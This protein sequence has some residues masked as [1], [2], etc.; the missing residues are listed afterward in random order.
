M[1]RPSKIYY[2]L[3]Q[4]GSGD[5]QLEADVIRHH[6]I[7]TV[8]QP[9]WAEVIIE[10]HD[11]SKQTVYNGDGTYGRYTNFRRI[12]IVEGDTGK[13]SFLGRVEFCDSDNDPDGNGP[14]LKIQAKDHLLEFAYASPVDMDF[15]GYST[16][17]IFAT[18]AQYY[19]YAELHLSSYS[20][21]FTPGNYILA[22]YTGFSGNGMAKITFW[23]EDS[24]TLGITD[25]VDMYSYDPFNMAFMAGNTVTE[26]L[27]DPDTK[28][29]NADPDTGC[30]T[31][32]GVISLTNGYFYTINL[33]DVHGAS[34]AYYGN[35]RNNS[36]SALRILQQIA[37]QVD[38]ADFY[39][40]NSDS[41]ELIY[42][43][44]LGWYIGSEFVPV[45][46]HYIPRNEKVSY[47]KPLILGYDVTETDY[48]TVI[49]Y[50]ADYSFPT[51]EKERN[52][53]IQVE[54]VTDSS[55]KIMG[56]SFNTDIPK[57]YKIN[58]RL[59]TQNNDTVATEQLNEQAS[60]IGSKVNYSTQR[61][62]IRINK[63]PAYYDTDEEWH[64]LRAGDVV[65][66]Y[67]SR[68]ETVDD[69]P[70]MVI[71]IDY[72]ES[73][74]IA[75][76]ELVGMYYNFDL[77]E[78]TTAGLASNQNEYGSPDNTGVKD[79]TQPIDARIISTIGSTG[80][81]S[82]IPL[83]TIE[84]KGDL[85]IGTGAGAV[86][87]LD[88]GTV[89]DRVLINDGS[90]NISWG[91]ASGTG[92]TKLEQDSNPT[93]GGI[94]NCD[95]YQ[96]G[97][98]TVVINA[99]YSSS[100]IP[101]HD[102]S[103][104]I[105]G[106]SGIKLMSGYS[107]DD[108]AGDIKLTTYGSIIQEC[109][110]GIVLKAGGVASVPIENELTLQSV[111]NIKINPDGFVYLYN[112]L[113]QTNLD[114]NS[115]YRIT[116]LAHPIYEHD[117]IIQTE[118]I[119]ESA[120]EY[121]I[122]NYVG[123][124]HSLYDDDSPMLSTTLDTNGQAI[125]TTEQYM[126]IMVD[127]E[128]GNLYLHAPVIDIYNDDGRIQINSYDGKCYLD[129]DT[130]QIGN[131]S[132]VINAGCAVETPISNKIRIR[133]ASDIDIYAFNHIYESTASSYGI[134]IKAGGSATTPASGVLLLSATDSI[135]LLSDKAI[136]A[137]SA[138]GY[139]IS[140]Y[141]GSTPLSIPSN[142]ITFEAVNDITLHPT[143]DV[144]ITPHGNVDIIPGG[145]ITLHPASYTFIYHGALSTDFATNGNQIYSSA[146][147]DLTISSGGLGTTP[148]TSGIL[149]L[150]S[151]NY[152]G[153]S[154]A[155]NFG[156]SINAGALTGYNF[157]NNILSLYGKNGIYLFTSDPSYSIQIF[158]NLNLYDSDNDVNRDI[159]NGGT[160]NGNNGIFSTRLKIPVGSNMY[161]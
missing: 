77:G 97:N 120:L 19:R 70:M 98:N 46:M 138:S 139:G 113:L 96:I 140:L 153:I 151:N 7:D 104:S 93:L 18:I 119:T 75:T 11:H 23:D 5:W 66:V 10:D 52:S 91:S 135:S 78:W 21:S 160:I 80:G 69:K 108:I 124:L 4:V 137:T 43:E 133:A 117:A 82:G 116:N 131:N 8:N 111:G 1:S 28:I 73:P 9:R 134:S 146:S 3:A 92:M 83:S 53:I 142:D 81:G 2:E 36:Q 37:T 79:I 56:Q 129:T 35:F 41:E 15:R 27:C 51:P 47:M 141:A 136:Y 158:N 50:N 100:I 30:T 61:G 17:S 122:N 85:V 145:A 67:N 102:D 63:Y 68:L 86:T 125:A 127:N 147:Q 103:V 148:G 130:C 101:T 90:G 29:I 6:I 87:R 33:S 38:R 45:N 72:E 48:P 112:T 110:Y 89:A 99:G 60:Y 13:V 115:V 84:A 71:S 152:L 42:S 143:V 105:Y 161:S 157:Y 49:T 65:T 94:L 24:K 149:R 64:I 144:N 132:I 123:A 156:I 14:T 159:L 31:N 109:T 95:N 107:V 74:G 128:L 88:S 126:T 34:S 59:Y 114:A 121:V 40:D 12:L 118:I 154:S 62:T 32:T 76:I 57:N 20:G 26:Y 16:G 54:S 150:E 155:S 39:V 22:P 44:S 25:V 55:T 106:L 58:K